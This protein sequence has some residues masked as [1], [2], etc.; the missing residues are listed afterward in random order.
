[1]KYLQQYS[2]VKNRISI[3]GTVEIV[4]EWLEYPYYFHNTL[5]FGLRM[6]GTA[7]SFGG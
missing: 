6:E 3:N 4:M 5:C 7:S 1:V 2:I